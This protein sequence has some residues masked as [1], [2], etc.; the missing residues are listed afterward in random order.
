MPGEVDEKPWA[1]LG[2][3]P[4]VAGISL[5]ASDHPWHAHDVDPQPFYPSLI[6]TRQ[7]Y[8]LYPHAQP[9]ALDDEDD[10]EDDDGNSVKKTSPRMVIKPTPTSASASSGLLVLHRSRDC[11][12][13]PRPG[14]FSDR[15]QERV[16]Q[17]AII[18]PHARNHRHRPA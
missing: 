8:H 15:I 3:A 4:E 13:R 5:S 9:H 16:P 18:P 17:L 7:R 1:I 14:V 10:D 2:S 12:H 6:P 11:H